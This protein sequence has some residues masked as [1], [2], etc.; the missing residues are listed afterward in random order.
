MAKHK[1]EGGVRR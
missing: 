1:T